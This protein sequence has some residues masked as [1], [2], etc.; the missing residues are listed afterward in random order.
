MGRVKPEVRPYE[1]PQTAVV[2][3]FE[4][5]LTTLYSES[6]K[7]VNHE[8]EIQTETQDEQNEEAG[9]Y[10]SDNGSNRPGRFEK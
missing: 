4:N 7:G 1:L 10:G 9:L 8:K 5:N 6:I 3:F 2:V